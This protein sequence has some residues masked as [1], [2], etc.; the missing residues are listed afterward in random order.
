MPNKTKYII[1]NT[2]LHK[3]LCRCVDIVC[4]LKCPNMCIMK[5]PIFFPPN[6]SHH[7]TPSSARRINILG[8]HN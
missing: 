1:S 5:S 6:H 7:T 2:G 4:K 8:R 3:L